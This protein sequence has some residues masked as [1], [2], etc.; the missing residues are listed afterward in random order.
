M[1][2][3][4]EVKDDVKDYLWTEKYRPQKIDDC[5]LPESIKNMFRQQRDSGTVQNMLLFGTH[6]TGKS[7]ISTA[8]CKEINADLLFMN[9]SKDNSVA[10]VRTKIYSFASSMSLTGN[11]R[12]FLGDEF[13]YI[14]KEGQAA[15]RGVIEQTANSCRFI[16]T[17]NF[18]S[19]IIDPLKSRLMM[20]DFK[21]QPSEKAA[22]ATQFMD[23]CMM[24]LETEGVKFNKKALAFL[25]Q[26]HYPDFRKCIQELQRAFNS[27]GVIDESIMM[28]GTGEIKEYI[29]ALREKDYKAARKWIAETYTTPEDFFRALY[30]HV[31]DIFDPSSIAQAILTLNTYQIQHV[32]AIDP[33]LNMGAMT[34]ELMGQCNFK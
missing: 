25:I 1:A 16:F 12:V 34:V 11:H 14:S 31:Y 18:L 20:I 27:V 13:D 15:L 17:C 10:D 22:L 4:E 23:R 21:S 33:E 28:S 29:K 2:D 30:K 24:I 19:K 8:L 9:C 6:G 3:M 7:T 5:I 26:K 32:S